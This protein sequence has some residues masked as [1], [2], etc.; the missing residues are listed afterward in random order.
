M[1]MFENVT[2]ALA[3]QLNPRGDLTPLDS[4]IDFKRFHPF[5]L[6][7][8]KR[9]STLFWG[10]RYV[11]TDYTLLDVLEPGN[12]PS[13]PT[14]SGNFGFKN[15][16]D[17]RVEGEVDVPKT[18]K[19]RGTA[20]LSRN[21]TLEVQ[22]LSVAP[23]A[24]ES[25]HEERKLAADHPFLKEMRDRG[26]NLYVVMEVVETVQE[27][28]LERAGKAEGC[29]SLPFF[30]PLGLQ[31]SVNHKEAVT[32]PKGCVL[33][34]RVRQ[35]MVNGKDE[36]DIPHICND[37]MQTF[38]PEEKPG[39]GKCALIQASDVGEVH[40]DF[41]TLK[42]EVQRETQEV[43][44]LSRVG[45]SSL[46]SSLSKLLG[47]KKELQ[48]LELALEGAL[49]KGHKVTLEALPKDIVLSKEAMDAVLY[50]LGALTVLSEAQQKLLVKS[51]EKKIL[52]VQLKLVESMMEQNFLQDKEGIFPLQPELLSSL[53]E[54]EL[55]LTEAL[56]G[57]SGLEVQRSGPQYTWDPDAL[58][59]LCALYAGL[60]LLHLLTK[61]S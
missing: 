54:E 34:F 60:S 53:G 28:T 37:S 48:D 30:A 19:V 23:K 40:E 14:D 36:W 32:I 33:A 41:G 5:C 27:V 24:L 44:K 22:T 26:E 1:T 4:L 9:K 35:L 25:L 18:V 29:F 47:K 6:V 45:Q 12:S 59:H 42:E 3:R 15:M 21:S 46:L 16:L 50:F 13:D 11:R 55:T 43:E 17:A 20:G 2:R 58:P 52:P 57:L 8:R 31:G 7:L 61:A 10:A 56:V 51:M 49:D 39:E 38:P